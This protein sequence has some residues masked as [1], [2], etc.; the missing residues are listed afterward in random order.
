MQDSEFYKNAFEDPAFRR[1]KLEELRYFKKVEVWFI[2]L[3]VTG[4]LAH[5]LD[6]GLRVGEWAAGAGWLVAALISCAGYAAT[7]A[8]A[9]ALEAIEEREAPSSERKETNPSVT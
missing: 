1:E 2:G 4:F 5:T 8:R 9:G 6:A 7:S 3:S